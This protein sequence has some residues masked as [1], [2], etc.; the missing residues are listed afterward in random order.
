MRRSTL[1]TLACLAAT[2]MLAFLAGCGGGGGGGGSPTAAGSGGSATAGTLAFGTITGFG[3][4]WVNGTE[5]DTSGASFRIDDSAGSQ[6]DLRVGMVVR[7][8]GSPD[9]GSASAVTVDGALKGRVE[10]VLDANRMLV[11]GQTVRIDDQT[12]FEDGIVPVTGDFV[13]VHG[14][15]A[16]DGVV[17]AGFVE[18][19]ATPPSPPFAVKG[20]AGNHDA[21]A[22]TFTVGA[23][24]VNYAGATAV[25][26][27][28]TGSWNGLQVEV[29]GTACS[30]APV[31]GTLTASKVERSGLHAEDSARTEVEGYVTRST[32]NGFMLGAQAVVVGAATTYE[33]GVASDVVAG[34]KLEVEGSLAG[35]VLSA[36]K[37]SLRDNVR[38]EGDVASIDSATGSI[39][40]SGIDGVTI[41]V[42][43]LTRLE[44]LASPASL[45]RANHVR[46][47]GRAGSSGKTVHAIELELR[48]TA[49][50]GRITLQGPVGTISGHRSVSLLGV[51]VDTSGVAESEFKSHDDAPI[52]RAAFFA[53]IGVGS[54][55]KARG[56]LAGA[57]VAWDEMEL[58]D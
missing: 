37:V 54:V 26:D 8:D 41:G 17:A 7:I 23:L 55:V 35:G 25:S 48:S 56:R 27:L 24:R 4:V 32:A 6:G 52:G 14:L 39:T 19:K 49:P 51:V 16:G 9:D 53:A 22:M 18:R 34:S 50:D 33:G 47:K 46:L 31:C 30:G 38:L 10:R 1:S 57:G 5:Y 42:N 40:L 44:G 2:T 11:M 43:S 36:R 20:L 58:Q 12:H 45:G 29:K 15:V 13:E 28:P 3:S 21:A